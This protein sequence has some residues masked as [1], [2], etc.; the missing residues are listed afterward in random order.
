[1]S[2]QNILKR[3]VLSIALSIIVLAG[4]L[5]ILSAVLGL[6][7][8]VFLFVLPVLISFLFAILLQSATSSIDNSDV[9][10]H[11]EV[12]NRNIREDNF[13]TDEK[14]DQLK[15]MYKKNRISKEEFDRR[16]DELLEEKEKQKDKNLQIN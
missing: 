3:F 8:I 9:Y 12:N 4:G 2:D 6:A 11:L 14:I 16:L 7:S 5:F 13:T 1:M 10:T 15:L